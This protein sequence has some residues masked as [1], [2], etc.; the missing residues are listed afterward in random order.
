MQGTGK[1]EQRRTVRDGRRGRPGPL[2]QPGGTAR[3]RAGERGSWDT[4]VA[5]CTQ[6]RHV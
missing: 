3:D 2:A 5:A 1:T 6:D 4:C